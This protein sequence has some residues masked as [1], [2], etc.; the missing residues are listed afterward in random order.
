MASSIDPLPDTSLEPVPRVSVIVVTWNAR[1]YVERCLDHLANQE[2]HELLVVDNGSTDGTREMLRERI[3]PGAQFILLDNPGFGTAN[4]V[5]AARASGRYL[6]LLNGD[7]EL[8]PDAITKLA[9]YL[10]RSPAVCAV[11]PKLHTPDG[12]A[13]RSAGR[14]PTLF[15]EL[16]NKTMLHWAL[17]YYTY[18]WWGFTGTRKVGWLTGACVMVRADAFRAV[19][20][21]DESFFMF[22]EDVDLCVRLRT[23]GELHFTDRAQALHH[24]G[25]SSMRS[26]VKTAMLVEGEASSRGYFLKHGGRRALLAVRLITALAAV[27]RFV[28][29]APA[30]FW[31]SLRP[32]ARSRLRAY[33]RIFLD[34]VGMGTVG[35][36]GAEQR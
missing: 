2:P 33:P 17:P 32:S 18:G 22:M 4:N 30:T 28:V 31:P 19:G 34:S 24:G 13:Q 3:L 6:L 14:V 29:W 15:T 25:Q 27:M 35:R 11:G 36:R 20:G 1:H 21:F 26:D 23:E 8:A 5:A 12:S 16:L 7:C 9:D 10:G